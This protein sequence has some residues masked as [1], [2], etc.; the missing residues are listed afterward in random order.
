VVAVERA[1]HVARPDA[2]LQE[3]A[4]SALEPC[5][6]EP[7]QPEPGLGLERRGSA[8]AQAAP[9]HEEQRVGVGG[10]VRE[11]DEVAGVEPAALEVDRTGDARE[12]TADDHV[13][14]GAVVARRGVHVGA[15]IV[16]VRGAA[17]QRARDDVGAVALGLEEGDG[18]GHAGDEELG[19]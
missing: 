10:G 3:E 9:R 8:G 6:V 18:V 4:V 14:V 15:A 12:R 1:L 16:E 2:H 7:R 11:L 17:T 5:L 19:P 13:A